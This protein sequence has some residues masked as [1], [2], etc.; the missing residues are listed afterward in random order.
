MTAQK[1]QQI[2]RH[3]SNISGISLLINNTQFN[4]IWEAIKD[5]TNKTTLVQYLQYSNFYFS[6]TPLIVK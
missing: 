2:K 4:L 6:L 5:P 1:G 3:N